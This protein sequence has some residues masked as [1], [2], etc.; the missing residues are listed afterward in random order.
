MKKGKATGLDGL[1][2]EHLKFS[3]PILVVVVCKLFNLFVSHS[4]IPVSFGLSYTVSIPKSKCDR[5]KRSITPDYFRRIFISSVI[6]KLFELC[7]FDL[8]SDY[9][10]TCDRQ[11]G[12]E[13]H[14]SCS[15]LVFS[16]RN[17]IYHYVSSGSTVN[18]STLD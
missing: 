14:T 10:Y 5:R 18:V 7:I 16:V 1:T 9:F 11:R 15:Q 13:K 6:S 2:R 4:H 12:F 8:Y 3:H 17:V